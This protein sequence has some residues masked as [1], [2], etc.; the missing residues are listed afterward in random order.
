M[1]VGRIEPDLIL[2][3]FCKGAWGVL[4]AGCPP[5][6]CEHNSSYKLRSRI[7]LLKNLL[8][9]F[10]IDP[11]RVTLEWVSSNESTRLK[12]LINTMVDRV[13]KLGP[14]R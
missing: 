12:Q 3:A 9:Q 6:E 13:T 1:C 14:P 10:N 8:K 7:L 11:E 5:D 2:E 4:I